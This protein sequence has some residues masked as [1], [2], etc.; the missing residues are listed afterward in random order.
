[1]ITCP[2]CG[3]ITKDSVL[4]YNNNLRKQNINISPIYLLVK[5]AVLRLLY[6]ILAVAVRL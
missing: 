1:M 6:F 5:Y 2:N 3:E 4:M